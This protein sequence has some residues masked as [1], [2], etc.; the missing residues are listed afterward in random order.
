MAEHEEFLEKR[1][2]ERNHLVLFGDTLSKINGH[3]DGNDDK[4]REDYKNI[5][6]NEEEVL[7][8]TPEGIKIYKS[9]DPGEMYKPRNISE[10]KVK[11]NPLL[12]ETPKIERRYMKKGMTID[13]KDKYGI[14]KYGWTENETIVKRVLDV[15]NRPVVSKNKTEYMALVEIKYSHRA[16]KSGNLISYIV[17]PGETFFS[18]RNFENK[19]KWEEL[20]GKK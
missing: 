11:Y 13:R 2:F 1:D 6:I 5:D 3:P 9:D 18:P 4:I 15:N 14:P 7:K 16:Y 19:E 12:E 17:Y 8:I 20:N 10:E